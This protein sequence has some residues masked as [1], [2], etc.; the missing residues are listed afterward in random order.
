MSFANIINMN[1]NIAENIKCTI[2]CTNT[3]LPFMID[4]VHY[5]SL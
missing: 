1:S 4:L 3:T 5:I 2:L